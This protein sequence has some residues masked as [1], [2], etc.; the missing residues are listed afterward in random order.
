[1]T[2]LDTAFRFAGTLWKHIGSNREKASMGP[3][4]YTFCDLLKRS[5]EPSI[6]R[7]EALRDGAVPI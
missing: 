2:R 1:M 7:H 6:T 4:S 5:D 3:W